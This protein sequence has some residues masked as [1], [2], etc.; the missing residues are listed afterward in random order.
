VSTA[1]PA[2]DTE[3]P[4]FWQGLGLPGLVD[5]HVHLL[6][7]R[8]LRRIWEYFD[9]GG[10]LVG[11]RWPVMYRGSDAERVRHLDALGVRVFPALAYPHRAAGRAGPA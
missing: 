8:L 6:P 1:A 2:D 9:S 4:G 7:A 11:R 3:V 5:V 10:P